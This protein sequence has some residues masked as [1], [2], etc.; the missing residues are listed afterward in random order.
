MSQ[1]IYSKRKIK[2]KA[3]KENAAIYRRIFG[4]NSIPQNRTYWTLCNEQDTS[5]GSEIVQLAQLGLFKKKQFHGVDFDEKIIEK[6]RAWHPEANWHCG[7]WLEIVE[8]WDDFNAAMVY[9]DTTSWAD[10]KTAIKL[11]ARTMMLCSPN[12]LL[13]AN[14]MLNNPRGLDVFDPTVLVK[15][16]ADKIPVSELEK[17]NTDVQAYHYNCSGKTNMITYIL[18]KNG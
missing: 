14:A 11:V 3:R 16:M 2:I 6:N 9:L 4:R 17:W 5:R 18:H 12:T 1:P 13:L 8:D 7:D 10:H 15:K